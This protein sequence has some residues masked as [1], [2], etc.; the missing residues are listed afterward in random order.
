M[1]GGRVKEVEKKYETAAKSG[2]GGSLLKDLNL[3][4]TLTLP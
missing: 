3:T 1:H 4:L 2:M